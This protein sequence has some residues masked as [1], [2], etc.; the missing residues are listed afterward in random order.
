M[1]DEALRTLAT[2]TVPLV[3]AITT[4]LLSK[5][6]NDQDGYQKLYKEMKAERDAAKAGEEK[7]W[8]KICEMTLEI[9]TLK[10]KI[11]ELQADL[12][13]LKEEKGLENG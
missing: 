9:S 11:N 12:E 10:V 5:R 8:A 2:I 13:E 4:Y 6:K 3:T 7:A 1:R